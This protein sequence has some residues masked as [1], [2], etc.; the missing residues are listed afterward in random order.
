MVD[1]AAYI[2]YKPVSLLDDAQGRYG[3]ASSKTYE[4]RDQKTLQNN[5]L[6]Q[7]QNEG[8]TKKR[9]VLIRCT[10]TLLLA[11]L[12]GFA[13]FFLARSVTRKEDAEKYEHEESEGKDGDDISVVRF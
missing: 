5:W 2:D 7:L 8:T 12:V 6:K 13:I 3:S 10:L 4:D 1:S 11:F 9:K